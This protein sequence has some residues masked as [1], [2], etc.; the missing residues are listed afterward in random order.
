M[1]A[2]SADLATGAL[3]SLTYYVVVLRSRHF[4]YSTK[5]KRIFHRNPVCGK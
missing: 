4:F 5:V 3:R 2:V 1:I